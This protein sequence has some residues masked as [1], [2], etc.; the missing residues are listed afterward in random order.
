MLNGPRLKPYER[1]LEDRP[2]R[3]RLRDLAIGRQ[4][5]RRQ[6]RPGEIGAVIERLQVNERTHAA[7]DAVG[8]AGE[9]GDRVAPQSIPAGA[10]CLGRDVERVL[11]S[12]CEAPELGQLQVGGQI[13]EHRIPG[14]ER[15][16]QRRS[17]PGVQVGGDLPAIPVAGL[18]QHIRGTRVARDLI[19]REVCRTHSQALEERGQGANL[20]DIRNRHTVAAAMPVVLLGVDGYNQKHAVRA[21]AVLMHGPAPPA[22]ESA[23]PPSRPARAARARASRDGRS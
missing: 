2:V 11:E 12:R 9:R 19:G 6:R 14:D 17:V 16:E 20:A 23:D 15:L 10:K 4:P 21:Q 18:A 22:P 3:S 7:V 13:L 8:T 1:N 5:V